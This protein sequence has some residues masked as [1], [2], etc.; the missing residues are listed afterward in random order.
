MCIPDP[1]SHM[2]I[3]N[4]GCVFSLTKSFAAHHICATRKFREQK[5]NISYLV[6][7]SFCLV[8]CNLE[9]FKNFS[10]CTKLHTY[11]HT[12]LTSVVDPLIFLSDPDPQSWITDPDH[13]GKYITDPDPPWTLRPLE[14]SCQIPL[15]YYNYLLT[16]DSYG[17][18]RNRF[19]RG[20]CIT[21][22]L[23]LW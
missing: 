7:L 4:T 12:L 1:I 6:L 2:R 17:P 13:G 9:V 11:Q 21:W 19:H 10:S 23:N 20:E 8:S 3:R 18:V 16:Y 15:N 14:E 22:I 5:Q